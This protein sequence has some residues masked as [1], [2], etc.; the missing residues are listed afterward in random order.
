MVRT[1]KGYDFKDGNNRNNYAMLWNIDKICGML[2][3]QIATTKLPGIFYFV[4][5]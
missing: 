4:Q 3:D 1:G 5:K 2:E